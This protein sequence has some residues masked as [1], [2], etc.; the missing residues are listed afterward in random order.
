MPSELV[1]IRRHC[2][3]A[4]S[5]DGHVAGSKDVSDERGEA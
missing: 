5:W 2:E 4:Y 1:I 3:G